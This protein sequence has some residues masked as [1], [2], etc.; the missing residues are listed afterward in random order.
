[1][2]KLFGEF[3]A[4]FLTSTQKSSMVIGVND[5]PHRNSLMMP[6]GWFLSIVWS[7]KPFIYLNGMC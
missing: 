1:M 5:K 7:L 6:F 2:R 3:K 4:R